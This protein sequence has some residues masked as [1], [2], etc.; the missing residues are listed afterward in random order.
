[1]PPTSHSYYPALDSLRAIAILL[2]IIGHWLPYDHTLNSFLT[3]GPLGVVLFFVLSGYLITGILLGEKEKLDAEQRSIGQIFKSFYLKR[4]LRIFP[5]YYLT[6]LFLL[7]VYQIPD[8]KEYFWWHFF[9]AS[10]FLFYLTKTWYSE[11]VS[12]LWSLSVEEQFYLFWPFA[13]LFSTK[14]KFLWWLI[15]CIAAGTL[16]RMLPENVHAKPY[17]FLQF[18]MPSCIDCFALGGL[19]AY[20]QR[21]YPEKLTLF[22]RVFLLLTAVGLF[23]FLIIVQMY[24]FQDFVTAVF[25]RSI[26]SC[27]AAAYILYVISPRQEETV[28]SKT[29]ENSLLVFIGKISYSMYLW[30]NLIPYM[31]QIESQEKRFLARLGILI[32]VSTF[33]YFVLERPLLSLKKYVK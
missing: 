15:L 29:L 13:I 33:S 14:R 11:Y 32:A 22:R 17:S 2:V 21:F 9:Y 28:L 26:F 30:H 6:L 10:N 8:V 19:I 5:I 25:N 20:V 12:P 1:M 3:N 18:L 4:S 7:F 16:F 27:F 23:Y 31:L 24:G